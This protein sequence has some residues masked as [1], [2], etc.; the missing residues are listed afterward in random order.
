[1][2][3]QNNKPTIVSEE[4]YNRDLDKS[5]EILMNDGAS[6]SEILEYVEDYKSRFKIGSVKKK[7]NTSSNTRIPFLDSK[8][9]QKGGSSEL[10]NNDKVLKEPV[11]IE[12]INKKSQ[13]KT[14][15]EIQRL[16]NKGQ[17]GALEVANQLSN[18]S[19]V[20]EEENIDEL[21]DNYKQKTLVSEQEEE[22]IKKGITDDDKDQSLWNQLGTGLKNIWNNFAPYSFR[23]ETDRLKDSR[24]TAREI[25]KNNNEELTPE[26]LKDLTYKIEFDKRKQSVIDSKT[27]DF[28]ESLEEDEQKKIKNSLL[29]NFA[30]KQKK[31]VQKKLQL[32]VLKK[33]IPQ[34]ENDLIQLNE[35]SKQGIATQEDKALFDNTRNEML[36]KAVELNTVINDFN[37]LNQEIGDTNNEIDLFRRNYNDLENFTS[38][39]S[40]G[41]VEI[42]TNL[43]YLLNEANKANA[44]T[45][46]S[47]PS[48][49]LEYSLQ[50][51]NF[52]EREKSE[53]ERQRGLLKRSKSVSDI[54]DFG[55]LIE[56]G[57]NTVADQTGNI[58]VLSTTGGAGLGLTALSS[59]GGKAFEINKDDKKN[60][61]VTDPLKKWASIGMS[62]GTTWLSE[63]ITLGQLN[64]AKRAFKS[65]PVPSIKRK[66]SEYIKN[67]YKDYF[68]DVSE[69]VLGE[70]FENLGSNI[71]DKYFL[72]K[73]ISMLRG[74]DADLVLSSAF[75]S[76]VFK[77][78]ALSKD[79]YNATIPK[80]FNQKINENLAEVL[81]IN[82]TL[83]NPEISDF[84]KTKL[85]ERLDKKLEENNSLMQKSFDNLDNLSSKQKSRIL[86]IEQEIFNYRKE[87]SRIDKSNIPQSQKKSMLNEIEKDV[88]VFLG[89]KEGILNKAKG[90]SLNTND[91]IDSFEKVDD[92]SN[93]DAGTA[94]I[95]I[96]GAKVSVKSE[97]G[98][99]NLKSIS[100]QPNERGQGKA[101]KALQEVVKI[102]DEKGIEIKLD[103]IPLD[104]NTSK[105]KLE[106]FYSDNGFVKTEGD[107]MIRK[108]KE[109]NSF[110]SIDS[111][112]EDTNTEFNPLESEGESIARLSAQVSDS[113]TLEQVAKEHTDSY[114]E[115][116][117][118]QDSGENVMKS[119][120]VK[121]FEKRLVDAL[122]NP[123]KFDKN[124]KRNFKNGSRIDEN[125]KIIS[126]EKYLSDKGNLDVNDTNVANKR[127]EIIDSDF[128][129]TLFD[130]KTQEL[131]D[132]GRELKNKIENGEDV[133]IL[134]AREDNPVN[135]QFIADKLGIDPD[136]IV[137]GLTPE[138]KAKEVREGAVFYD[139]NSKNIASVRNTG[140]AKIVKIETNQNNYEVS[141]NN[142]GSLDIKPELGSKEK[143]VIT[144][145][146][147]TKI[148]KEYKDNFDF[149]DGEATNFEGRENIT[150]EQQAQIISEESNNPLEIAQTLSRINDVESENNSIQTKEDVIAD[151]LSVYA[152]TNDSKS[153]V[154]DLGKS[155]TNKGLKRKKERKSIDQ[156]REL[157]ENQLGQSVSY[158]DVLDFL[159]SYEKIS[160]YRNSKPNSE[161]LK[162]NLKERFKSLTG[163]ELNNKTLNDVLSRNSNN[164]ESKN[165]IDEVPFQTESNQTKIAGEQLSGLVDRLNDTGLADDV[166]VLSD[167]QIKNKLDNI[168]FGEPRL[169]K[170]II[171]TPFGFVHDGVVYLNRDK[172][173][174]DTPIHE[175]GHLWNS[176]IKK[177]NPEVYSRG[178]E[179]IKD[180]EYHEQV[181]NNDAYKE[182]SEEGKLEE[183]LAQAI[184][185]K[186]VKILKESRKK[187]F[188]SWF[189]RLFSKVAKGLGLRNM[190]GDALS[191]LNLDS[192]TDLASAELL[193]GQEIKSRPNKKT[194]RNKQKQVN[195]IDVVVASEIA[196][197]NEITKIKKLINSKKSIS[198][199]VKDIVVNYLNKN[200]DSKRLDIAGKREISQIINI[201]KRENLTKKRLNELLE[202]SES[203]LDSLDIKILN[204]NIDKILNLKFSKNISGRQTQV[205]ATEYAESIIKSIKKETDSKNIEDKI[206]ELNI[207]LESIESK[208]NQTDL[209]LDRIFVIQNSLN[210]LQSKISNDKKLSVNKLSEAYENIKQVYESEKNVLK[211]Q[212]QKRIDDIKEQVKDLTES[213]DNGDGIVIDDKSYN[214]IKNKQKTLLDRLA[215]IPYFFFSPN[216]YIVGSLD[217]LAGILDRDAGNSRSDGRFISFVDKLKKGLQN[218]SA[219]VRDWKKRHF[220]F[221]LENYGSVFKQD[222][223]LNEVFDLPFKD[224]SFLREA[225]QYTRSELINLWQMY[226]NPELRDRIKKSGFDKDMID[227]IEKN[228]LSD[229]DI[230]YANW[231]FDFYNESYQQENEIYKKR[232]FRSMPKVD[233]YAG[234]VFSERG[235]DLSLDEV[236]SNTTL[237]TTHGSQ[238]SRTSKDPIEPRNVGYLFERHLVESSHFIHNSENFDIFIRLIKDKDFKKTIFKTSGKFGKDVLKRLEF[239]AEVI[240]NGKPSNKSYSEGQKVLD[241]I[242]NNL[243]KAMLA[244]NPIAFVKQATSIVNAYAEMPSNKS[245]KENI[246]FYFNFKKNSEHFKFLSENSD[247]LKE[248]YSSS[249]LQRI[250][251]GLGATGDLNVKISK[252]VTVNAR[253]NQLNRAYAKATD[254]L[255][256]N[257]KLGD[258]AGV[259]G[260]IPVFASWVDTYQK[261]GLSLQD[262]RIK[263]LDK[264]EST[265]DRTQ[266]TQSILGKSTLQLDPNYR[267]FAMF[268][269]TQFQNIGNVVFHLKQIQRQLKGQKYKGS[270]GKNVL[271]IANLQMLQPIAYYYT[272]FMLYGAIRSALGYEEDEKT[273]KNKEDLKKGLIVTGVLGNYGS[274]PVFAEVTTFILDRVLEK[275]K[276]FANSISTPTYTLISKTINNLSRY[277]DAKDEF[278]K[279]KSQD[280]LIK[281]LATLSLG[282]P[283]FITEAIQ[284]IPVYLDEETPE[285]VKIA[286]IIGYSDW[287]I[288][289]NSGIDNEEKKILIKLREKY[290][291]PNARKKYF[292]SKKIK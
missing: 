5:V 101:K 132:L 238:K 237:T 89:E 271:A 201:V 251:S 173:K 11:F 219:R 292:K 159:N 74:F 43:A 62:I 170:N 79:L 164:Q 73:D 39:V 20:N 190:S 18:S 102:A 182:L 131:T 115:Y 41:V 269:S 104:E 194:E 178:L 123:K 99:L 24:K 129:N 273:K 161:T 283:E 70:A 229:K 233:F 245:L 261:Q 157:A 213:V 113:K 49:P 165:D 66:A 135:R 19:F 198:K 9:P 69:E 138:G 256:L 86:E 51:E 257:I 96:D 285:D 83:K 22:E 247:W 1:M 44:L 55:D 134:T 234:K 35:K 268:K 147:R 223:T 225:N 23:A 130:N 202:K 168:K 144:K 92:I 72:D 284:D 7:E 149:S 58:V 28:I 90:L 230:N 119:D 17:E 118:E 243:T 279:A 246:Q 126:E 177:N 120:F 282:F 57:T 222:T 133:R 186:G 175:F 12:P 258:K 110:E 117:N 142:D 78:P 155:Y 116:L 71:S 33:E 277:F 236:K 174:T 290:D 167:R 227:Y 265:A 286:K 32:E 266:Q 50:L 139:D 204:K 221:L 193:S 136:R 220:D 166:Q 52:L 187:K 254:K 45:G 137:L 76:S 195:Q 54:S 214:K 93:I 224:K 260:V 30:K 288:K 250:I 95:N 183:A 13:S 235:N 68:K 206:D 121:T 6:D 8:E 209:D 81:E 87:Y 179:L 4:E 59:G 124:Q 156:I 77:V 112:L 162:N 176:Y 280:R 40:L 26:S 211:E 185:E 181:K 191:K 253:L 274:T 203:I 262:A 215:S 125:G 216:G 169:S 146:E 82:S 85:Q 145:Q 153:E 10:K 64:K 88:E 25:L 2:G 226:K 98:V 42:G 278:E 184:G 46:T 97:K 122:K 143:V 270:F 180:S 3:K 248:R 163:L 14:D 217:S 200:L 16:N 103:V 27:E 249:E 21:L 154:T 63:R 111:V 114:I 127:K 244:V 107:T 47:I 218:E 108:P 48:I 239:F 287:I 34:L 199:S 272:T 60:N 91:F 15:N 158:Q 291:K 189:R 152:L 281:N 192:F 207:E 105:E 228:I 242:T 140:K 53:I 275:N 255:M 128:D 259:T 61:K 151:T 100:V 106:K 267:Y 75:M 196:R 208:E 94:Q 263:A 205:K 252:N 84:E 264:F 148:I 210:I 289:Q 109:D 171:E 80:D 56:W 197:Q 37:D 31:S 276:S 29:S 188:N 231:L 241:K 38:R 240:A 172:V 36:K 65:I 232:Y 141:V 67:N 160:D 150:E 212:K